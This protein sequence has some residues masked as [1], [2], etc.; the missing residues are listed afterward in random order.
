MSLIRDIEQ[1]EGG[2][3]KIREIRKKKK[4][5]GSKKH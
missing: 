3:V 2:R 1:I 4:N 5:L